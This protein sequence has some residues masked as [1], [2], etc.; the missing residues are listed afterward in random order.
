MA[1]IGTTMPKI[2]ELMSGGTVGILIVLNTR[3]IDCRITS[4]GMVTTAGERVRTADTVCAVQSR[5]A[6]T[7][8]GNTR[9]D[10]TT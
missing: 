10:L 8:L 4:L 1:V 3:P 5:L 7:D 6:P 2:Q 9:P